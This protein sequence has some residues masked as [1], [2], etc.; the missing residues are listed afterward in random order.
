MQ[1]NFTRGLMSR[2]RYRIEFGERARNNIKK[3]P[4]NIQERI[5]KAIDQRLAL[6]PEE[7]GKPLTKEWKNHRRLRVGDYRVIYRIIQDK[8]LVLIVEIDARRDIY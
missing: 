3:F 7:V 5:I 4:K 6:S 1:N 2:A 8:I